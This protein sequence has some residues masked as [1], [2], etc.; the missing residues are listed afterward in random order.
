MTMKYFLLTVLL[1]MNLY[2]YSQ[3]NRFEDINVLRKNSKNKNLPEAVLRESGKI[4]SLPAPFSDLILSLPAKDTVILIDYKG[5]YYGVKHDNQVGY[6]TELRIIETESTRDFKK[7]KIQQQKLEKKIKHKLD[8]L[9]QEIIALKKA[10]DDSIHDINYKKEQLREELLNARLKN[11]ENLSIENQWNLLREVKGCLGGGQHC[12]DGKCG[13]EYCVMS[14]NPHWNYFLKQ[15]SIETAKFLIKQIPDTS[16]TNTH[17]CP[18]QS[19]RSGELAIYSLQFIFNM[20]WLE[21]SPTYKKYKEIELTGWPTSAQ[22]FLWEIIAN[23]AEA[24]NMQKYW[25]KRVQ[26]ELKNVQK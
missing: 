4:R 14:I 6:I 18:F 13:H 11:F 2:T 20:N 16:M 12:R 26:T 25:R 24:E 21:L 1:L 7:S 15:D 3:N 23:P 8:S 22:A 10:V 17:T 19:A 5:G 9:N